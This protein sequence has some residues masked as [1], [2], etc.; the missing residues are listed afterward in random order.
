VEVARKLESDDAVS[1]LRRIRERNPHLREVGLALAEALYREG[2]YR[3]A[4]GEYREVERERATDRRVS[5]GLGRT[6]LAQG[7]YDQAL[8]AFERAAKLGETSGQFHADR[9]ETLMWLHRYEEATA[10]YR[11]A[12]RSNVEQVS[13]RLNLGIALAQLG[14]AAADEAEQ[15]LREVLA[16][17][18]G[19]TR[20]WEEL[21]KLGRRF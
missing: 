14:P 10:A 9:G 21:Q 12:L 17:D 15:R 13:W 6:L 18:P 8:L 2:L 7:A 1:I 20:A 5:F 4:E 19:N 11:Q 16:L 3:Q